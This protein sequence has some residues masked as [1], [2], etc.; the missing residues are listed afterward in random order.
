MVT[1]KFRLRFGGG[2]KP[3][4]VG[5]R[6][7]KT[8]NGRAYCV[9][10]Y[11][12]ALQRAAGY[13]AEGLL[14]GPRTF[15]VT[16]VA[17]SLRGEAKTALRAAL[18]KLVADLRSEIE[19]MVKQLLLEVKGRN[20]PLFKGQK[21][22]V[23]GWALTARV[24]L[25]P[26]RAQQEFDCWFASQQS[27]YV[28][29]LEKELEERLE[30]EDSRLF[31]E[32]PHF[33]DI[34]ERAE[35]ILLRLLPQEDRFEL[36]EEEGGLGASLARARWI[37][38]E[39]IIAPLVRDRSEA[40]RIIEDYEVLRARELASASS[41]S[42]TSSLASVDLLRALYDEGYLAEVAT[43]LL[44][45]VGLEWPTR[46]LG[47]KLPGISGVH[48]I[49]V[50]IEAARLEA[51][52]GQFMDRLQ[53]EDFDLLRA[54]RR[55]QRLLDEGLSFEEAIERTGLPVEAALL[56]TEGPC[57]AEYLGEDEEPLLDLDEDIVLRH[58]QEEALEEAMAAWGFRTSE[59]ALGALEAL[60]DNDPL[61]QAF[62]LDVQKRFELK[63]LAVGM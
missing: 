38:R 24:L 59:E 47:G 51:S 6:V 55:F 3:P 22:Y 62:K 9:S 52:W 13:I 8:K 57:L 1:I 23:P 60:G 49:F 26:E 32:G 41:T 45:M 7:E 4:F 2:A 27:E 11:Q 33:G 43:S 25:L 21:V 56:L 16:L 15:V 63:R 28:E 58:F 61:A 39:G 44:N 5:I 29:K 42:L 36:V 35:E 46:I 12:N 40:L 53:T 54:A 37:K 14:M 34:E 18:P 48:P 10:A 20:V 31:L 17:P 19:Q 50:I 30:E